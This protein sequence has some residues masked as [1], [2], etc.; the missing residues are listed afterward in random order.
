ML[1]SLIASRF[2]EPNIKQKIIDFK[3]NEPKTFHNI[4]SLES[5]WRTNEE[6]K[7]ENLI[8]LIFNRVLEK[9]KTKCEINT[10]CLSRLRKEFFQTRIVYKIISSYC[11]IKH[12]QLFKKYLLERTDSGNLKVSIVEYVY[13][14]SKEEIIYPLLKT[15]EVHAIYEQILNFVDKY[16]QRQNFQIDDDIYLFENLASST[17]DFIEISGSSTFSKI[18]RYV[19]LKDQYAGL[20]DCAIL[21]ELETKK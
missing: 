16:E 5:C 14:R 19:Q 11:E 15:N 1:G 18:Q 3:L 9:F 4:K 20:D 13:R 7:F 6:L 12:S 21:E 17:F 8:K 10:A 2:V